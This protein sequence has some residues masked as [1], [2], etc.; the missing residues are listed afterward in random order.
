MIVD[1]ARWRKVAPML[2]LPTCETCGYVGSQHPRCKRCE[3]IAGPGHAQGELLD[4]VC[5]D[6][7]Q[8]PVKKKARRL[9]W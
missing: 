8:H 9:E 7:R 2:F 6:C 1:L 4:G 5:L 3:F